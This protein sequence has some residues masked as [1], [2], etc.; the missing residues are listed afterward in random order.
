MLRIIKDTEP[1]A[2]EQALD[3]LL[4][5]WDVFALAVHPDN[6]VLYYRSEDRMPFRLE[7]IDLSELET[8]QV[9]SSLAEWA[10]GWKSSINWNDGPLFKAAFIR[11]PGGENRLLLTA[12]HLIVDGVSWRLIIDRLSARLQGHADMLQSSTAF[13]EY[14]EQLHTQ[15][16]KD[17]AMRELR[18]LAPRDD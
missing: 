16:A 14:A 9:K 6:P 5:G 15:S 7:T 10:D 18:L 2:L 3:E 12:H 17:R 11:L 4:L 1:A 8:Q 13:G